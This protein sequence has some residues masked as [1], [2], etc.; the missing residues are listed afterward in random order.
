[1][2][3]QICTAVLGARLAIAKPP[4][5]AAMCETPAIHCLNVLTNLKLYFVELQLNYMNELTLEPS[6]LYE[7]NS[8]SII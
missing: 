6:I 1:V 7:K 3:N 5:A 4:G 8:F 2:Q